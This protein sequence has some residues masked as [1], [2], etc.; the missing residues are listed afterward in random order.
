VL[1]VPLLLEAGWDAECDAVL[2]VDTPLE[3]RRRRAVDRGWSAEEFAAREASQAPVEE[4]RRRATEV[5]PGD[6]E[7]AARRAVAQFW[8]TTVAPR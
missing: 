7:H 3:L 5:V 6:D 8:T 2:F 1:D 4:K